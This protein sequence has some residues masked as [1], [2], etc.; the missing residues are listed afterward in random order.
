MYVL[1]QLLLHLHSGI[2]SNLFIQLSA[3]ILIINAAIDNII[4][5]ITI[6]DSILGDKG[7][8]GPL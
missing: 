8:P 7:L 6:V 3:Y 4:P 2:D 1:I 5:N